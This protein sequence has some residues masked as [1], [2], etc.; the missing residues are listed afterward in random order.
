MCDQI[1]LYTA[2]RLGC[3]FPC[4]CWKKRDKLQR[5]YTFSEDR[6]QKELDLIKVVRNMKSF[7]ILLKNFLMTDKVKFEITHSIKNILDIDTDSD[8]E[9]QDPIDDIDVERTRPDT[10][11]QL[12]FSKNKKLQAEQKKQVLQDFYGRSEVRASPTEAKSN[13]KMA[14]RLALYKGKPITSHEKKKEEQKTKI[15]GLLKKQFT[16][17]LNDIIPAGQIS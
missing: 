12:R 3:L 4:I 5:L 2:N 11:R 10:T 17:Q 7:K 14:G 6:I 9:E 15:M 1:A 8:E 16:A 13:W